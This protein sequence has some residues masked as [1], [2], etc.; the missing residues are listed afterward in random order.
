MSIFKNKIREKS[1]RLFPNSWIDGIDSMELIE[2]SKDRQD[3]GWF[4]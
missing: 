4:S 2:W 1:V 3:L